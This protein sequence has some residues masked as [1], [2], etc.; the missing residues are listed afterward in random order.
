MRKILLTSLVFFLGFMSLSAQNVEIDNF[1]LGV[2]VM[3]APSWLGAPNTDIETGGGFG[4]GAGLIADWQFTDNYWIGTGVG[5]TSI[6][7]STTVASDDVTTGNIV[8]NIADYTIRY[9]EIPATLKLRT[10][11][12]GTGSLGYFTYFGQIGANIG[13]PIASRYDWDIEPR[14]IDF[15]IVENEKA[16]K[17]INEVGLGFVLSAGAE[18]NLAQN[19]NLLVA[20][21]WNSGFTGIL[22]DVQ[23]LPAANND[24][25]VTASYFGIRVGLMF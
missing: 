25:K 11:E 16:N 4:F 5:I 14:P 20:L 19:T 1:R 8:R 24:D 13:I 15:V 6:T 3:P 22:K 18:Y 23:G 21:W 2:Y 17:L 7:G 10:G 9:L 12:I